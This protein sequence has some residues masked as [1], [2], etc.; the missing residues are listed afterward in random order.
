M[1]DEEEVLKKDGMRMEFM[2][3]DDLQKLRILSVLDLFEEEGMREKEVERS[4]SCVSYYKIKLDDLDKGLLTNV[5]EMQVF[6]MQVLQPTSR[7]C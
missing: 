4:V 5:D 3:D 2:I 7:N 1:G 6:L